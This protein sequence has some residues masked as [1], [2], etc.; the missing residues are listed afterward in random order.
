MKRFWNKVDIRSQYE[1][2][3]W[4]GAK[5]KGYGTFWMEGKLCRAHRIAWIL[6]YGAISHDA[7][8]C[9]QC[10]NPGCVNPAHLF[11]GT[12]SEN[13]QDS[14][15]KGRWIQARAG[16]DHHAAKVSDENVKFARHLYFAERRTQREIAAFFGV[17]QPTV[18]YWMSGSRGVGKA[19]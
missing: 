7:V 18:S 1:C 19:V 5:W 13:I 12:Q 11:V 9:H 2:W 16:Q 15:S 3:E 4:L 14:V 10:D 6:K 8:I 17:T